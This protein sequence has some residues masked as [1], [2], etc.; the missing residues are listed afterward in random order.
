[1]VG[2]VSELT[3]LD[4]RLDEASHGRGG[5]ILLGGVPGIG[6]SRLAL[7]VSGLAA[8]RGMSVLW[9]RC[10]E[11]EGARSFAP[12]AEALAGYFRELDAHALQR[13]LGH[14]AA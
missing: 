1:M 6:K 14:H 9:G 13:Q 8:E 5:V 10:F 12:W 2:R 4:A 3:T 11:G 7:E